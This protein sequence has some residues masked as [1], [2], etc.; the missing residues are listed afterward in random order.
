[1]K[2]K[3]LQMKKKDNTD[4]TFERIQDLLGNKTAEI[5]V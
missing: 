1:L 2:S 4:I 3:N 5:F